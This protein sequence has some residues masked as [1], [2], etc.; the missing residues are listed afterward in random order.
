MIDKAL[1]P[2]LVAELVD[3]C[4]ECAHTDLHS[5]GHGPHPPP[6]FTLLLSL[7]LSLLISVT[8]TEVILQTKHAS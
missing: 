8:Q 5:T 7:S 4:L 6:L 1:G 2:W 3:A